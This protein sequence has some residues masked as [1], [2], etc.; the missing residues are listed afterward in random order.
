MRES[1]GSMWII[2]LVLIFTLLFSSFLAVSIS[3]SK[4]FKVKNE[5]ISFIEKNEGLTDNAVKLINDYLRNSGYKQKGVC[6]SEWVG[7]KEISSGHSSMNVKEIADGKSKYYYCIKKEN[8]SD[9]AHPFRAYYKVKLFYKFD[10]PVVGDMFNF[11][12][13]G[14]TS[15]IAIPADR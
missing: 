12:V 4:S 11:Q 3:Y 8:I 6:E 2:G 5:V 10:L 15:D 9:G 14:Q 1:F 7:I 13:D